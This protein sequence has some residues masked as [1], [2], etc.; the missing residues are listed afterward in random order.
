MQAT[1]IKLRVTKQRK[2]NKQGS[3]AHT[4]HV[5]TAQSTLRLATHVYEPC[6]QE[7]G[8]SLVNK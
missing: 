6:M 7:A 3:E 1:L 2:K 8:R 5:E 4:S